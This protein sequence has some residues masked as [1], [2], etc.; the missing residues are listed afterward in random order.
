MHH[1]EGALTG[2]VSHDEDRHAPACGCE[3]KEPAGEPGFAMTPVEVHWAEKHKNA[4]KAKQESH[5]F[6][7]VEFFPVEGHSGRDH[8]QGCGVAENV[9]MSGVQ[10][11]DAEVGEHNE[12]CHLECASDND[13]LQVTAFW[14]CQGSGGRKDQKN[15]THGDRDASEAEPERRNQCR[16]CFHDGPCECR[17]KQKA[18]KNDD[19][20]KAAGG[21]CGSSRDGPAC[22][23]ASSSSSNKW[24]REALVHLIRTASRGAG[25]SA[26]LRRWRN[27]HRW[28]R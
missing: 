27:R 1:R 10:V 17:R 26:F 2:S 14:P 25:P 12:E 21:H 28:R 8:E 3:K 13:Q 20:S 5:G 9:G 15:P 23:S 18:Q 7:A 19:K 11:L 16:S 22:A 4:K 24:K 6:Q